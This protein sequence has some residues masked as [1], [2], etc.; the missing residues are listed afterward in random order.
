MIENVGYIQNVSKDH[1]TILVPIDNQY[2]FEK[3]NITE[4]LVR[5]NDGRTISAEQR[6]KIYA[7]IAD[8]ADY[9][10]DV[11]DFV[12]EWLKYRFIEKYGGE[13]FS[14]SDCE[15][16]TATDFISFLIDF[17]FE[18]NIGTRDTL[19]NRA[20]DISHYLYSCLANRRCAVCN[21]KGEVHHITGSKVGMGF[22]R[23]KVDNV[24][25][26][27]V[28]L[29]RKHH[30]AAHNDEKGFFGKYHIYGIKLD[31]Y[32]IKKLKL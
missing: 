4:C 25:R 8:I 21:A 23:G 30:N 3:Q 7:T 22:N 5:F 10:G 13:Y 2:V 29:C 18:Q 14:L 11:P 32:L 27:A 17:C 1:A 20:D 15:M 24:G 16:T 19:L 12:K 31:E 26:Q 9:T 28:C 6:K